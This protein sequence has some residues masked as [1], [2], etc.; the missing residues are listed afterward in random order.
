MPNFADE[1]TE[2]AE[3]IFGRREFSH[4]T[5]H[6]RRILHRLATDHLDEIENKVQVERLQVSEAEEAQRAEWQI[7]GRRAL[8]RGIVLALATA[9][10]ITEFL[11]LTLTPPANL[12]AWLGVDEKNSWIFTHRQA[13]AVWLVIGTVFLGLAT[14][15]QLWRRNVARRLSMTPVELARGVYE[16][17]L[18]SATQEA[19]A[20]S[21]NDEL[22]PEGIVAFPTHAPRLVELD[23]SQ[24]TPSRTANYI[25]EFILEHDSSAIGLAGTR[26]SG[27]STV[28]RALRGDR[29][30]SELV[31]VVPSP[32][33]YDPGE[34]VRRLLHETAKTIASRSRR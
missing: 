4:Y 28:M 18:T 9:T 12:A 31:T 34:F 8:L 6:K 24:V 23:T 30:L 19:V 1:V 20:S 5:T 33:R 32:V 13:L 25:K 27:K 10:M 26:G 22:G 17:A 21:I 7:K 14:I 16:R 2:I 3:E 11:F 29:E 15:G